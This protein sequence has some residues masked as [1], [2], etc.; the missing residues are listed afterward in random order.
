MRNSTF[1]AV[2]LAF[3]ALIIAS[4]AFGQVKPAPSPTTDPLIDNLVAHW[5]A[6]TTS[7][8]DLLSSAGPLINAYNQYKQALADE[9]A[10][11]AALAAYWADYVK[12]LPASVTATVPTPKE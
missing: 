10:K 1:A 11:S 2:V 12:G 8:N 3:G 4:I 7:H 5:Q 9:Q 6:E